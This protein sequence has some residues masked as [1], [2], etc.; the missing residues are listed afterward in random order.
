MSRRPYVDF[1]QSVPPELAD[2][3][4][5][6]KAL[7]WTSGDYIEAHAVDSSCL[8]RNYRPER[9]EL[10]DRREAP[11]GRSLND[12][13]LM[14]ISRAWAIVNMTHRAHSLVLKGAYMRGMGSPQAI[15]RKASIRPEHWIAY[16]NAA[17][18]MVEDHWKSPDLQH[19]WEMAY[20]AI[21]C[22]P[23]AEELLAD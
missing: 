12:D 11:L 1:S 23:V 8:G 9:G 2:I 5:E 22:K 19:R 6:V 18:R 10:D 17:L 7:V 14:K 16:R 20:T 3:E 21:T 4:D 13:Q 15:C